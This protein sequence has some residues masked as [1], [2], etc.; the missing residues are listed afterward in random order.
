MFTAIYCFL[1]CENMK[2][3]GL[4]W[5]LASLFLL[6][7]TY[8][9]CDE[10]DGLLD[11]KEE[12]LSGEEAFFPK[13]YADKEIAA[14]YSYTE[15]NKDKTKTE[16]VFLFTDS[17][18]VVTK[19]KVYTDGS[20]EREIEVTGRYVMIE[21][22]FTTGKAMAVT[23]NGEQV[24]VEIR[25]GQLIK[26]EDVFT[27]QDNA[28]RPEATD[29][30][31]NDG[32]NG[33]NNGGQYGDSIGA[34]AFF[35]KAYAGKSIAAWYAYA[36]S[37][38]GEGYEMKYVAAIYFFEK[39]T[40]VITTVSYVIK[41]AT[42]EHYKR[43]IALEGGYQVI[44]GDFTTGKIA[45]TDNVE[46]KTAT[47]VIQDGQLKVEDVEGSELSIY[48]KQD[49]NKVPEPSDP[50]DNG[51]QGGNNQGGSDVPAFFPTTYANKTVVAW[52]SVSFSISTQTTVKAVFL[53]ED[54]TIIATEHNVFSREVDLPSVRNVWLEGSYELTG[55]YDNGRADIRLVPE[56]KTFF[57]I[58]NGGLKLEDDN[59]E[60]TRRDPKDIPDALDP[61]DNG[62]QGGVD[63]HNGDSIGLE[64]F[65]PIGFEDKT[66]VAWF[67][68]PYTNTNAQGEEENEVYA[69]YFLDGDTVIVTYSKYSSGDNCELIYSEY[70][71]YTYRIINGDF[72]NGT[73]IINEGTED[74]ETSVVVNGYMDGFVSTGWTLQDIS[75]LPEPSEPT[76]NGNQGGGDDG[77]NDG[78]DGIPD[79][80]SIFGTW[81]NNLVNPDD[82]LTLNS[83]GTGSMSEDKINFTYIDGILVINEQLKY[84]VT[85]D[86]DI[87][88]WA[89]IDE[90]SG[91]TFVTNVWFRSNGTFDKKVSDGRW[92]GYVDED[93]SDCGTVFIFNGNE[94]DIY[95]IA[96]GEHIKG[97]FSHEGG[98][99]SFRLTDGYN[100]R[101]G[102]A[103]NWSWEAGNLDPETLKL[104]DGYNWWQMDNDKLSERKEELASFTFALVSDVKAYGSLFRNNVFKK[105][106]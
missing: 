38:S 4:L 45:I 57:T 36:G 13:A 11:D 91:T 106:Q 12:T 47:I 34:G 43:S 94:V 70:V 62:N 59:F 8:T 51:N 28:K 50:T 100:A 24:M 31:K 105:V 104:T 30:V 7:L 99:I 3:R 49:N 72:N 84:K 25:D 87:M 65:F 10:L 23:S 14:W 21:G 95:I 5:V 61:T 63:P 46:H 27:K 20:Y 101:M 71:E 67:T 33:N 86:G 40:T 77:G 53:F 75:K 32:N 103:D 39:D 93:D 48:I 19:N 17:T 56:R 81:V 73:I 9:S 58:E 2:N 68:M 16:A 79:D 42:G 66:V 52:Y 22:D 54:K 44:E 82:A 26:G 89:Y 41:D 76:D 15:K 29:P 80:N 78:G 90:A 88:T 18:F 83:N 69:L 64:A 1:F 37:E 74:E 35:P 102:D 6:C 85:I 98:I 55:D 60:Y 92:N 97:S 96:W